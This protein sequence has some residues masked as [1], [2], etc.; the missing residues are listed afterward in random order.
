[1]AN[2]SIDRQVHGNSTRSRL[3][4]SGLLF[5]IA[6]PPC[7]IRDSV[8]TE[9][10]KKRAINGFSRKAR[11]KFG[12]TLASTSWPE[13]PVHISLTYGQLEATQTGTNWKDEMKQLGKWLLKRSI[14]GFWR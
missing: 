8:P 12:R 10:G 11:L 14:Y 2:A 4:T 6:V 3:Q 13:Q 9:G 7:K 1:M 5:K